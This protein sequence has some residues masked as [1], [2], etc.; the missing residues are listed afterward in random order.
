MIMA[1]QTGMK[2][3]E[4]EDN[5]SSNAAGQLPVDE[6]KS[7]MVRRTALKRKATSSKKLYIHNYFTRARSRTGDGEEE[8]DEQKLDNRDH[9]WRKDEAAVG[10]RNDEIID[11]L[12]TLPDLLNSMIQHCKNAAGNKITGNGT[13]GNKQEPGPLEL[14]KGAIVYTEGEDGSSEIKSNNTQQIKK[15]LEAHTSVV[16]NVPANS[17][18]EEAVY[19]KYK[20]PCDHDLR[21]EQHPQLRRQQKKKLKKT[22]KATKQKRNSKQSGTGNQQVPG[23]LET[24]P[25]FLQR[26]QSNVI[27]ETCT[28]THSSMAINQAGVG[29]EMSPKG[30]NMED[31]PNTGVKKYIA[32]PDQMLS[33]GQNHEIL[34][35]YSNPIG[36]QAI[37]S[38][39]EAEDHKGLE[40]WATPEGGLDHGDSPDMKE[41]EEKK[42]TLQCRNEEAEDT[43]RTRGGPGNQAGR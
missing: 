20:P 32:A 42:P 29:K 14:A 8:G 4:G 9:S 21:I 3:H 13:E 18:V 27:H 39:E 1:A 24:Y 38:I 7:L 34:G 2:Y 36:E 10:S 37:P 12:A 25:I 28:Q 15:L 5:E 40:I 35:V 11:K 41:E 23:Q 33:N 16:I 19:A 31:R 17:M 22:S 43:E 26:P 6:N 30:T